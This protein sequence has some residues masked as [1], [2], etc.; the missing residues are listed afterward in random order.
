MDQIVGK[1]QSPQASPI[2]LSH[3]QNKS[4]NGCPPRPMPKYSKNQ[5]V[6]IIERAAFRY[7][8]EI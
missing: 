2:N 8:H 4:E 6:V 5:Y 7:W 1:H 3:N